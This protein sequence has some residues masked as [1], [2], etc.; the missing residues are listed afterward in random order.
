M[1][2]S[3]EITDAD[4]SAYA[5]LPDG[6]FEWHDLYNVRCPEFRLGRLEQ[7]GLVEKEITGDWPDIEV[8]YRKLAS[9]KEQPQ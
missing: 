9:G 2:E 4:R 5:K 8:R 6:W 1:A 3:L 7:R